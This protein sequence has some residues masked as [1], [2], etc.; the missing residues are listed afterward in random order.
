MIVLAG[1][2]F[3]AYALFLSS[4]YGFHVHHR[5]EDHEG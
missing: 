5:H 1:G 4:A 3:A 2:A